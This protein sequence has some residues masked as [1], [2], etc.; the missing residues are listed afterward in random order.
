MQNKP[1]RLGRMSLLRKAPHGSFIPRA[2]AARGNGLGAL[3]RTPPGETPLRSPAP[4]T[5]PGRSQPLP[6]DRQR[7]LSENPLLPSPALSCPFFHSFPTA[8]FTM[9]QCSQPS[10]QAV[11]HVVGLKFFLCPRPDTPVLPWPH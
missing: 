11:T 2:K 5:A 7:A 8:V 10:P 3:P 4:L 1:A 6:Q 9:K